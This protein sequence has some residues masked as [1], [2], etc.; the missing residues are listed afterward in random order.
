MKLHNNSSY[1]ELREEVPRPALAMKCLAASILLLAFLGGIGG[2]GSAEAPLRGL[3]DGAS[4][5]F[6]AV[7]GKELFAAH[8]AACHGANGRGHGPIAGT[9]TPQPADLS[10][11]RIRNDNLFPSAKIEDVIRNGGGVLGHGSTDM[12]AWGPY[13]SERQHPEHAK[14]RISALVEYIRS[15]QDR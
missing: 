12:L 11:L 15:L 10:K 7:N 3:E 1:Q 14:E 9:M 8:C 5:A 13:F 6:E 2:T 4:A